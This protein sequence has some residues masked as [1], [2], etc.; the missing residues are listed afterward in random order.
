MGE[1]KESEKE[2]KERKERKEMTKRGYNKEKRTSSPSVPNGLC[3]SSGY[4]GGPL[5]RSIC[6]RSAMT[7]DDL[8]L[9]PDHGGTPVI[10]FNTVPATLQIS[11][12]F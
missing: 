1:G 6:N 10:I 7:L 4:G 9:L 5:A 8:L 12:F 2:R 3:R 11:A